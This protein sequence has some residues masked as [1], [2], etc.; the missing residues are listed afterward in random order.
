MKSALYGLHKGSSVETEALA[1]RARRAE[2]A[3]FESLWIGD[4]VALPLD[5]PDPADEHRLELVVSLAYLAA[6]TS[7]VRLATGVTVLPLRQP[8]LLAKQLSSID[9]LSKGR[10]IVGIGVGYVEAELAALGASVADRAPRPTSTWPRCVPCG[11][12]RA[13]VRGAFRLLL[14]RH[15]ASATGPAAP[16]AD[17]VR[18]ATRRRL[19][20]AQPNW[21]TAGTGGNWTL[22]RRPG[23]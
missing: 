5:A 13:V 9:V 10:L 18:R 1:R 4:H 11:T 15:G 16:S 23:R 14:R 17:R 12:S 2:D 21:R 3:G 8:V 7:R 22:S 6:L 19:P 20:P